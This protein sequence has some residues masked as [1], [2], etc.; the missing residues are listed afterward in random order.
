MRLS[1]SR[2]VLTVMSWIN[3]IP[4]PYKKFC[5]RVHGSK[6]IAHTFDR[7]VALILWNQGWLEGYEH[8]LIGRFSQSEMNVIDAGANI[9]VH[10]LQVSC[11]VGDQGKVWAFEP[12]F[13]NQCVL[14][15][16]LLQNGCKK[17]M[18]DA[19]ALGQ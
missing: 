7:F 2:F 12:N 15:Q 19:A 9:G 1:G 10:T 8:E 11:M 6:M 13:Q 16:N 4:I 18:V 14:R 3:Q 5:V 17:V